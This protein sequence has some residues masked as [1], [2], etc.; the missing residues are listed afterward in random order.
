M[1]S[2]IRA[3]GIDIC[4]EVSGPED[5][6][7]LLIIQ[8]FGTQMTSWPDAYHRRFANSGFRVIRFDNRDVGLS[9]K[10]HGLVPDHAANAKEMA[11]GRKPD[12]PYTLDDMADDAAALVEALG[13]TS[14][15]VSGASMGGMIAQL[16]AI[17]HRQKTR[18]LIS[19]MS[20]TSDPSLPRADPKAQAAL[21]SKPS[22]DDRET[23]IEHALAMRAVNASPLY[24]EDR[25]ELRARIAMNHDRSYYPE[26]VL[27]QWAAIMSSPPRTEMLK[28]L[29]C[30]T[31]VIHG[32]DDLLIKPDAAHHTAACIKGAELVIVP[33]WGHNMPIRAVD[34]IAGP[35]IDFMRKVR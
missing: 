35:M 22:N 17:R 27:R 4:Y 7:P 8:G 29:D 2:M 34:A 11:E 12:V 31:L 3:N 21:M 26:G 28:R 16:V 5:G 18:S 6:I 30:P 14:V 10:F 25:D 15:H 20:T 19:L 33:G 32:A 1:P 13:F 9:Q 24:P 23:V